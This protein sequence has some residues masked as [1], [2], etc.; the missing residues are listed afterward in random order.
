[1]GGIGL[2]ARV[3]LRERAALELAPEDG[4]GEPVRVVDCTQT[5]RSFKVGCELVTE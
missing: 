4:P 2:I 3:P 5:L 1:M